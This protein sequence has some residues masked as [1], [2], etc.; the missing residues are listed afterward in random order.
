MR[1]SKCKRGFTII[2]VVMVFLL[3]LGVTFFIVPKNLNSIKQAKLISKWTQKYTELE[4]M[5]SVIKA[6]QEEELH[7]KIS[8][9]TDDGV[10][11]DILLE[12]IK[13]YLRVTSRVTDSNYKQHYMNGN[14]V[15]NSS[16]YYFN[17]YYMTSADE[18]IG[19]K[20]L[21]SDCKGKD[22]CAILSIDINGL[23]KP[24]KWGYDIYGVNILKNEV[25]PLGK[26]VDSYVL[27]KDCNKRGFGT[28]CS[29]YYLIGGK[30]D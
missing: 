24:N 26:G 18:V 4:Y 29:Y 16:K 15:D 19:L 13:P 7:K 5:F 10:R 8:N 1:K 28:F 23:E 2:E 21:N 30:F 14:V 20:W 6:Q 9:A 11:K 25:D 27:G 12:T 3:I 17:E 22:V